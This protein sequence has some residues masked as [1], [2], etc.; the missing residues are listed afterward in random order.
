MTNKKRIYKTLRHQIKF[1]ENM[2]LIDI[3]PDNWAEKITTYASLNHISETNFDTIE[4]FSFGHVMTESL[5]IFK[6]RFISGINN[7]MRILFN[8]RQFE[9]KKIIN[10]MELDKLLTII[11]LEI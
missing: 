3:E 7:R 8:I 9:I 10:P 6:M 5:F 4:N 2:K 1:L 11:A